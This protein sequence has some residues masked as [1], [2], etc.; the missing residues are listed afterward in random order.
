MSRL[1]PDQIEELER[2]EKE[3]TPGPWRWEV[4]EKGKSVNLTGGDSRN[5]FGKYDMTVMDFVRYG[6]GGAAPRFLDENDL[7]RRADEFA[8]VVAGREHHAAWFKTIDHADANLIPATR[9][10]LPAL[11]QSARN[12]AMLLD[13]LKAAREE[14]RLIRM[15]D[16]DACYNPMLSI[17]MDVAVSKAESLS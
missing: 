2:L 6:M 13:A 14:L 16:T 7:L 9:N 10:A 1:T 3:A 8:A 17:Q 4:N 15:K 12:E 11:L 5:G